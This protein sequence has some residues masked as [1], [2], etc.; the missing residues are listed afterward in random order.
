MGKPKSVLLRICHQSPGTSPTRSAASSCSKCF[1][2]SSSTTCRVRG[3]IDRVTSACGAC[4]T[5]VQGGIYTTPLA[6][7]IVKELV[8]LGFA[9]V[10]ET[11][12]DRHSTPS[13]IV[14]IAGSPRQRNVSASN[15]GSMSPL[16][17]GPDRPIKGLRSS[18]VTERLPLYSDS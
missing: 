17:S 14:P 10:G 15:S 13:P 3:R 5:P 12:G 7:A 8:H 16:S 9:G 6:A 18:W 4:F 2:P 1:P 11:R